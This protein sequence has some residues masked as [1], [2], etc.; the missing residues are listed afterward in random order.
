MWSLTREVTG[1]APGL[2]TDVQM[3]VN[4]DEMGLPVL[5]AS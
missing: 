4:S 3:P 5:K 2:V 1:A